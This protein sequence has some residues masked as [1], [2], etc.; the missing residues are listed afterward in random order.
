MKIDIDIDGMVKSAV[1]D[2]KSNKGLGRALV[3]EVVAELVK[4]A[5]TADIKKALK[6]VV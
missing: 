4:D 1:N 2:L 5:Y 3:A 6:K